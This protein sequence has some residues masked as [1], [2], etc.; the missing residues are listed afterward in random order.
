MGAVHHSKFG[1]ASSLRHPPQCKH[2]T[3]PLAV[4]GWRSGKMGGRSAMEP[5]ELTS[6]KCPK[7]KERERN[8]QR[9]LLSLPGHLLW[10]QQRSRIPPPSPRHLPTASYQV[11][12]SPIPPSHIATQKTQTSF[13]QTPNP[14]TG[15][16]PPPFLGHPQD[17]DPP[18]RRA[19]G[20]GT[21]FCQAAR[22]IDDATPSL[23]K[24]HHPLPPQQNEVPVSLAP[25]V[26]TRTPG[27]D[28]RALF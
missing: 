18:F 14:A 27:N 6:K 21:S 22:Q 23:Q 10:H 2:P 12:F 4:G 5:W 25:W 7:K 3:A 8:K 15:K 13:L 11:V 19:P 17:Q 16:T 1:P 9:G 20:H 24:T 26:K 28:S